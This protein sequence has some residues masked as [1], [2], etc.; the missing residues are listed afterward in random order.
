M[1]CCRRTGD[2]NEAASEVLQLC[3]R[4]KRSIKGTETLVRAEVSKRWRSGNIEREAIEAAGRRGT[5]EALKCLPT[6]RADC[7][8]GLVLARWVDV[9]MSFCRTREEF[10]DRLDEI[11]QREEVLAGIAAE[12][13]LQLEEVPSTLS[14]VFCANA[15]LQETVRRQA[16]ELEELR[17]LRQNYQDLARELEELRQEV[18]TPGAKTRQKCR[19]SPAFE[20]RV[21]T[22]VFFGRS[23]V[24]VF[25][26]RSWVGLLDTGS[27]ISILPAKILLSAQDDGYDIDRIVPEFP[28]D[29]SKQIHNASG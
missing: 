11:L 21:T 26:G 12:K 14:D 28:M 17:V 23:W 22:V 20:T 3:N 13:K 19:R 7:K 15:V 1:I 27:E 8:K 6:L 18:R 10:V 25:F 9:V 16:A 4:L 2:C 5:E 24:G 29:K